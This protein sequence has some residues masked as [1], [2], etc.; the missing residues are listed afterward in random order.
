MSQTLTEPAPPATAIRV[1][2]ESTSK[3]TR[4][5]SWIIGMSN[6]FEIEGEPE[7]LRVARTIDLDPLLVPGGLLNLVAAVRTR[8]RPSGKKFKVRSRPW[9]GV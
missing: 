9:A 1:P 3:L 2:R 5:G 8:R 4:R 6:A 7:G